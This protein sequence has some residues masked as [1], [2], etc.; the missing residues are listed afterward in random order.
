VAASVRGADD[1]VSSARHR[2]NSERMNDRSDFGTFG[3]FVETPVDEMSPQMKEAY[4]F[5]R[6]LRGLVPGPNKTWL[7]NPTLSKSIVPTGAYFQRDSTLTK[8]EIE[9]ARPTS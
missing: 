1:P 8:S 9:V 6:E 4:D 5:T 7:A 3:R 2:G